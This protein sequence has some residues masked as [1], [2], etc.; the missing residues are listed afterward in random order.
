MLLFVFERTTNL[1]KMRKNFIFFYLF[2]FLLLF[3]CNEKE[4]NVPEIKTFKLKADVSQLSENQRLL[5]KK[6]IRISAYIDSMFYYENY[7]D[8]NKLL[9][10]IDDTALRKKVLMYYGPWNPSNFKPI[11]PSAGPKPQGANYYPKDIT[12]EEFLNSHD[13]NKNSHYTFIRRNADGKLYSVFY[14][15]MFEKYIDTISVL[16][17]QA[18]E[19]TSDSLFARYLLQRAEDL[20]TD[21]YFKSDSIWIHLSNNNIDFVFGP[22]YVGLD[23]FLSIKNDHIA[24]VLLKDSVWSKKIMKYNTWLKFMQKSLPVPEIY[25]SEKPAEV[26]SI[27]V[28]DALYFAGGAKYGGLL[29]SIVQP[30]NQEI[31]LNYGFKNLQFRNVIYAKA[32]NILLPLAKNIL[33]EKDAQNVSEQ[34]FFDNTIFWEMGSSL[35][36]KNT[37]NGKGP[38]REALKETY[39]IIEY[40]KNNLMSMYIAHRLAEINK[41]PYDLKKSYYTFVVDLVRNIRF[42]L[43]NNY[44]RANLINLNYFID[45]KAISFTANKKLKIDYEKLY[46]L[47]DS[48]MKEIIILQGDGDYEKAKNFIKKYSV[49][50]VE[51]QELLNSVKKSVPVDIYPIQGEKILEL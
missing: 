23:R 11:I 31:Q 25:K 5:I 15:D 6:L 40:L 39:V 49:M 35:G 50:S 51:L 12:L 47:N 33:T 46:N 8:I 34:V 20:K 27:S 16:L 48:L 3:G 42:G 26:T 38:V 22:N 32:R 29:I 44:A 14:H 36:I 2:L 10:T 41:L 4:S 45:K 19:L 28:Y 9:Q 18:A 17:K 37:V 1:Q 13:L 7:G 24:I 43:K 30:L 21:N